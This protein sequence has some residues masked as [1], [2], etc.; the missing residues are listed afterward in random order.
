MS[1]LKQIF[2]LASKLLENQ[3]RLSKPESG[4]LL[5]YLRGEGANPAL[6]DMLPGYEAMSSG[7]PSSVVTPQPGE[8]WYRGGD[9]SLKLRNPTFMTRQPEGAAWYALEMNN[10]DVGAVGHYNVDVSNPARL[11]DLFTT[12]LEDKP[13]IAGHNPFAGYVKDNPFDWLY[14][15]SMRSALSDRGFDS[16][17]GSDEYP[18]GM[19]DALVP[20]STKQIQPYARTLI[21]YPGH[22]MFEGVDPPDF[23]GSGYSVAQPTHPWTTKKDGGLL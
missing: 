11:R 12:I 10:P 3:G 6:S 15:P 21:T 5:S 19:L 1:A 20:L 14:S 23:F 13:R 17:L 7:I 16:V 8:T 2:D 22:E 9:P 18:E 4:A